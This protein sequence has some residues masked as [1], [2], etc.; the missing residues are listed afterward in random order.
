MQEKGNKNAFEDETISK[1][2][3]IGC[4]THRFLLTI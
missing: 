2:F 3:S 4:F 1:D